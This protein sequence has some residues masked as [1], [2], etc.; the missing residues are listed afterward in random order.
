MEFGLTPCPQRHA[1]KAAKQQRLSELKDHKRERSQTV[2][3]FAMA[4]AIDGHHDSKQNQ[5]HGEPGPDQF[6]L[7]APALQGLLRKNGNPL[8]PW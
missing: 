1:D 4:R 6:P 3:A 5:H 2:G 7:A 8:A